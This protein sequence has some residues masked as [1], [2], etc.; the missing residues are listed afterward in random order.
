MGRRAG[1]PCPAAPHSK[2]GGRARVP[3]ASQP[4]AAA[5]SGKR[6]MCLITAHVP[7]TSGSL[8]RLLGYGSSSLR[9]AHSGVHQR[10]LLVCGC[11]LTVWGPIN[12]LGLGGAP[13][14]ALVVQSA[15]G[16][17]QT[18]STQ[19]GGCNGLPAAGHNTR[20]RAQP[21]QHGSSVRGH[22]ARPCRPARRRQRAPAHQRP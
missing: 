3:S 13:A 22:A 9:R 2:R 18:T 8:E 19:V 17:G 11:C 7:A 20:A 21:P 6:G 16:G 4:R 15:C 12:R 1:K 5:G 14:E 10:E